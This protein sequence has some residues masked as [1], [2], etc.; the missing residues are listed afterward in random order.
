[1]FINREIS[2]NNMGR[3]PL[4]PFF[5]VSMATMVVQSRHHHCLRLLREDG[6]VNNVTSGKSNAKLT[7]MYA[8][9]IYMQYMCMCLCMCIYMC[10][11]MYM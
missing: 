7:I 11:F 3:L 2:A 8:Y 10:M 4:L 5:I 6:L 1:M 9:I